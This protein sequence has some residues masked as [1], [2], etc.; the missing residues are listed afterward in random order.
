[1][2]DQRWIHLR[3]VCISRDCHL[4]AVCSR[5]TCLAE[6]KD[7]PRSSWTAFKDSA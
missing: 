1:M 7:V 5:I 2:I 3:L 6:G 4:T